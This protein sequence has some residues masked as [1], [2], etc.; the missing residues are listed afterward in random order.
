MPIIVALGLWLLIII[1]GAITDPNQPDN[2]F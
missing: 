1:L 2:E